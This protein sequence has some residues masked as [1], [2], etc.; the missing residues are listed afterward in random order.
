MFALQKRFTAES[1][2]SAEI[3]GYVFS[4]QYTKNSAFSARSAVQTPFLR[5]AHEWKR[6]AKGEPTMPNSDLAGYLAGSGGGPGV[7][8]LHP[9]WG[10]SSA[11][12][13][14]CDRLAALGYVAFAPDLYH[15]QLATTIE[16]AESLSGR[17][18]PEKAMADVAEA[19]EHLWGRVRN[20]DGGLGVM[21]LSLGAYFALRLSIADPDRIRAV[22]LF[23]GTGGG[24]FRRAKASYLGHFAE[25]DPY[26]PAEE[27]NKLEAEIQAA[28]R[29]VAFH[30]YS[31]VGHWFVEPDR[32]AAYNEAAARLAWDR[33]AT[34]LKAALAP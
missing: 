14:A 34:F 29:G 32:P 10:L 6:V 27:V 4:A 21:G 22:V 30:R 17:L 23:Y 13:A 2:E 3:L 24:D 7:L 20:R 9:W 26:E 12:R 8:V 31:G 15:G 5:C 18:D 11:V 28:G 1:A 25:I 19:A 33:T 16:E